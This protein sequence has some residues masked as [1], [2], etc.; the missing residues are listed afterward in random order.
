[1]PKAQKSFVEKWRRFWKRPSEDRKLIFRAAILLPFI[2]FAL[3]R[4]GFQRC[5]EWI[6]KFPRRARAPQ[7]LPAAL[8]NDTAVRVVRAVR[9]AELHGPA[10]PNC[11]ERSMTLWWLLRR[12]GIDAELHVGGRKEGGEFAAHAWVEL[13]GRVLND[14]AEIQQHYARFDAPI[15]AAPERSAAGEVDASPDGKAA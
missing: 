14:S 13:D 11:L 15:V 7:A 2:G 12:V 8:R 5:K 3:R 4:F 6:E 9:S 10:H 1:M